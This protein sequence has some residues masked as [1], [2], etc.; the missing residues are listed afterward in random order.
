MYIHVHVQ[1]TGLYTTV[2]IPILHLCAVIIL[3]FVKKAVKFF[4]HDSFFCSK[5][6]FYD[7]L[8]IQF[9]KKFLVGLFSCKCM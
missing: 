3:V 5:L 6:L 7:Q 4:C 9:S 8:M 2:N 1:Y